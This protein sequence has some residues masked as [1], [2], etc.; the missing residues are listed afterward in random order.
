[1]KTKILFLVFLFITL[2]D[3]YS[4]SKY[5]TYRGGWFEVD[6]P[7]QFTVQ[8]SIPSSMDGKYDS[9][10]FQ[11]P[12]KKVKYYIYSPQWSGDA[13]DIEQDLK[14]EDEIDTKTS[15]K[16][17]FN[18]RWFTFRAKNKSY[19]RS[20]MET[21]NEENTTKLIVGIEYRT[22]KDYEKYKKDYLYFKKSIKQFAD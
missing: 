16:N 1:M 4:E 3:L 22:Q 13:K 15:T 21:T 2:P 18:Y 19:S 5:R 6:Y 11:S 8:P 20:Y 12:D 17:G 14:L 10:Y 9:V 7:K